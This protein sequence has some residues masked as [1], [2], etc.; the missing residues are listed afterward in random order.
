VHGMKIHPASIGGASRMT[1]VTS[2]KYNL[3]LLLINDVHFKGTCPITSNSPSTA[4]SA[5]PPPPGCSELVDFLT[6]LIRDSPR[7]LDFFY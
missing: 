3:N 2:T 4:V 7:T 5:F 1:V 6:G